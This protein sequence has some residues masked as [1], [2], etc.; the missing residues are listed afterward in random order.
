MLVTSCQHYF[1]TIQQRFVPAAAQGVNAKYV[2]DLEGEGGGVWTVIVTDGTV[3]VTEGAA[4]DANVTFTISADNYV[5][6]ANGE[7]NGAKAV[8]TRKL[9][10]AGSIP[11]AHKM[12]KFLP[13]AK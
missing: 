1:E 8:L 11:L 4:A 9:K 12:N 10:V 7:L 3:T 5:K 2:Y 13:P 6:L